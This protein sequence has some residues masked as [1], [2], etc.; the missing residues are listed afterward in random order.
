MDFSTTPPYLLASEVAQAALVAERGAFVLMLVGDTV[1]FDIPTLRE[2]D[3]VLHP[4]L[5]EHLLSDQHF[6]NLTL[7]ILAGLHERVKVSLAAEGGSAHGDEVA[8]YIVGGTEAQA[9]P[10][11]AG[12]LGNA[13]NCHKVGSICHI[14]DDRVN[15][16]RVG[17][18]EDIVVGVGKTS[19]GAG[20]V[21]VKGGGG[22]GR[23]QS[24][25]VCLLTIITILFLT[26]KSIDNFKMCRNCETAGRRPVLPTVSR[27]FY[28]RRIKSFSIFLLLGIV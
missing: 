16:A 5:T 9:V 11:A 14:G 10:R 1:G 4:R 8:L 19:V 26:C 15:H 20:E 7:I 13:G 28:V 24:V 2:G 22:H 27:I 23:L 17:E 21:G 6:G 12:S 3:A 18:C 25:R